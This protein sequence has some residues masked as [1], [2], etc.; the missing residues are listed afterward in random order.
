MTIALKAARCLP[1]VTG[2]SW[3]GQDCIRGT[4]YYGDSDHNRGKGHC[5]QGHCPP[6]TREKSNDDE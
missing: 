2:A 3:R 5:P 1:F 4:G 6:N